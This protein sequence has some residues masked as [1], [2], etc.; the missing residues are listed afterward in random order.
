MDRDAVGVVDLLELVGHP[1]LQV[2]LVRPVG[3]PVLSQTAPRLLVDEHR[4]LEVE[5]LGLVMALSRFHQES[6]CVLDTTWA[7]TRWS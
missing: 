3:E 6:K 7:G 2:A 1:E 5:E 4:T